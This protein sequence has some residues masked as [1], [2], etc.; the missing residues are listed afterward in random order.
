MEVLIVGA[1]EMGRWFGR[2][3]EAD[4]AFADVDETTAADAADRIGGRTVPLDTAERFTAV[5]V[6]VPIDATSEAIKRHAP[7]ATDAILDLAGMITDPLEA[8]AAFD[9]EQASLHPLFA[10]ENAPGRIAIAEGRGGPTI[11][12]LRSDLEAAGNV[13]VETTP[14]EHDRAME[15]VQAKA[16]AAV[17]AFGLAADEIP[18]GFGTP[19]YD[20]L[21]D[22]LAEVTDGTPRV[23]ADIQRTF[24]GAEEVAEAAK[25]LADADSD[26]FERLYHAARET[27]DSA[28]RSE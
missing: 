4:L 15:T 6:A 19:V 23:Y 25:R 8:M 3:V 13:L 21:L 22:V 2:T 12:A 11:D 27:V 1:G 7:L 24:T 9:V 17:L 20:G 26:E 14:A 28:K 16:H 5:V 18:A 10:A